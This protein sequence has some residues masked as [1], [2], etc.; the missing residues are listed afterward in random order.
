ML[1]K[2][3]LIQL[4]KVVAKADKASPAAYSFN[5]ETF[6]YAELNETL[7]RELN[8]LAGDYQSFR[9]NKSKVYSIDPLLFN[10]L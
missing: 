2:E 10:R 3:Q 4:A 7:R 6:S 5:G 9:E 8:E 1:N